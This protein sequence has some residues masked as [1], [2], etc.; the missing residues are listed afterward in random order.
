MRPSAGSS[1]SLTPA[2]GKRTERA[3]GVSAPRRV[4]TSAAKAATVT[5]SRPPESEMP[6]CPRW[7]ERSIAFSNSVSNWLTSSWRGPLHGRRR[8]VPRPADL[9]PSAPVGEGV[10][11]RNPTDGLEEGLLRL[12]PPP[13]DVVGQCQAVQGPGHAVQGRAEYRPSPRRQRR[14]PDLAQKRGWVPTWSWVAVRVSRS[15][16]QCRMAKPPR[17]SSKAAW[18]SAGQKAQHEVRLVN[19]RRAVK[20]AGQLVAVREEARRTQPRSA[21]RP[22]CGGAPA[23]C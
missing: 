20:A 1:S 22:P 8:R 5:E 21:R 4:A 14:R 16:S 15:P 7:N 3:I 19:G 10:A 11:R 18:P 12:G 13:A 2:S 17:R 23:G 6:T 9:D